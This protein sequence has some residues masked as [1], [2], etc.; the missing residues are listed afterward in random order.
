[1]G[2]GVAKQKHGY[3]KKTLSERPA[4]EPEEVQLAD[5]TQM[6]QASEVVTVLTVTLLFMTIIIA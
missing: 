6:N 2:V 5:R 3:Q 4:T 1:M